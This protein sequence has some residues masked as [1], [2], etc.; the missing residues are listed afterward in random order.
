VLKEGVCSWVVEMVVKERR[1]SVVEVR[2]VVLVKR[3]MMMVVVVVGI[4]N[5]ENQTMAVGGGCGGG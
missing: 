1:L 2:V 3:A 4:V 5:Y